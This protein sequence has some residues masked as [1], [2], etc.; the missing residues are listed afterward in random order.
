MQSYGS[1][2]YVSKLIKGFLDSKG[3]I[4][5]VSC[6]HT[7]QQNGIAE[8]KHIHLV[9]ISLTLMNEAQVSMSFWYHAYSHAAFLINRMQCI[10]L[11]MNSPYQFMF[12]QNLEI[13]I[14]KIFGT[15]VYP[16]LRHFISHNLQPRSIQWVF[17]WFYSGILGCH[18]LW[19]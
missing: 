10:L 4:H 17:S 18:L 9:E 19:D 1:G 8:R 5:Q 13:H 16:L 11:D 14:L 2:E 7:P 15:A 6:P 3:I 12:W